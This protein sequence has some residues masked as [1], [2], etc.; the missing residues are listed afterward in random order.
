MAGD[1]IVNQ[2][3]EAPEVAP[4]E[5]VDNSITRLQV[6]RGNGK[7]ATTIELWIDQVDRTATQKGWN[8][9]R[10]AAAVCDALKD[11]AARWMAVI[12]SNHNKAEIL[13][14]WD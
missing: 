13:D 9:Q 5:T 14:D 12:K 6:W 8:A 10:T 7:D 11:T 3:A 1:D 4:N 2:P